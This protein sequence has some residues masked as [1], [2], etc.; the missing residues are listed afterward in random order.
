[1]SVQHTVYIGYYFKCEQKQEVSALSLFPDQS[2]VKKVFDG[3][4]V[5]IINSD[6]YM[7]YENKLGFF[8]V[9]PHDKNVHEIV[10]EIVSKLAAVY[11]NKISVEFGIFSFLE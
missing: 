4:D 3:S 5:Y 10:N 1:M 11:Q 7:Y 8:K 2:V 6:S 9:R